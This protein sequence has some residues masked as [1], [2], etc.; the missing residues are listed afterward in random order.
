M[1]YPCSANRAVYWTEVIGRVLA[2]VVFAAA[3][4]LWALAI[5]G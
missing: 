5:A 2:L 4:W 3:C 1:R